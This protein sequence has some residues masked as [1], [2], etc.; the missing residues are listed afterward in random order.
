MRWLLWPAPRSWQMRSGWVSVGGDIPGRR[1]GPVGV[2][3]TGPASAAVA[4]RT[5]LHCAV[6]QGSLMRK[7]PLA[8]VTVTATAPS[9]LHPPT[10]LPYGV[11]GFC[12]DDVAACYCPSN[13]TFGRVP[14]PEDAPLGG[15]RRLAAVVFFGERGMPPACCLCRSHQPDS[16]APPA[17]C[18]S[19]ST[20]CCCCCCRPH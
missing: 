18:L 12:D 11:A 2:V 13:T 16:T 17:R 3:V 20:S 8:T 1:V 19:A 4:Q 6:L 9:A 14:A 7:W 10:H 5:P 15:W